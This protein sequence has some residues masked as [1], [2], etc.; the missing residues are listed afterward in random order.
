MAAAEEVWDKVWIKNLITSDY[1]LKYLAFMQDVERRLPKSSRVLEAG[2]GTGQTLGL[3]SDRHEAFGLDISRAA[4]D[5]ATENC[6]N[7]VLG[8]IFSIPFRND[9]FDLVYNS[10]VIEH[11]RD[12]TNVAAIKEMVRVTRPSGKII[13]IVPNTLCLWYMLGKRM[14]VMMKNFEFGYEEDYSYQRLHDAS[15]R[16][17]LVIEETFGL[18]ALPPLATND[19]EIIPISLRKKIGRIEEGFPAKQYYAYTVG[20]VARKPGKT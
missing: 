18:Q 14:A 3:F 15:L 9:T 2:C 19:R 1:S 4:L 7:P 17:G 11:F 20:I 8:S 16:A 10:G 13:I 12:P 6:Q 5:L